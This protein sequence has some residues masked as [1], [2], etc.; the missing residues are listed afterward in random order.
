MAALQA[1]QALLAP[2]GVADVAGVLAFFNGINRVAD[3][4]GIQLDAQARAWAAGEQAVRQ[5]WSLTAG[6]MDS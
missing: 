3:A 6:E 4:T 5:R 2:A 1:L